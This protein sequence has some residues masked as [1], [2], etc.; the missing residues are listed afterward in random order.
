MKKQLL[1]IAIAACAALAVSS[2]SESD[3]TYNPGTEQIT[4]NPTKFAQ[5]AQS[6][7]IPAELIKDASN[8]VSLTGINLTESGKA[9]VELTKGSEVK[10]V[11]LNYRE[12]DGTIVILNTAGTEVGRLAGAIN[13]ASESKSITLRLSVT[14]GATTYTFSTESPVIVTQLVQSVAG[15]ETQTTSNIAR[16][17]NVQQMKLILEGDVQ[18][19]KQIS[20]GSLKEFADL[21]NERGANLTPEEYETL[22]L[23]IKSLTIDKNGIFA[24]EYDNG[25]SEASTWK[26]KDEA[27]AQKEIILNA[28]KTS[29]FGNKFL[30]ANDTKII[31][32]VNRVG[33]TLTLKTDIKG[34]KNYS[35]SLTLVLKESV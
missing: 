21:A 19:S 25:T 2:C 32:D 7:D 4:L 3:E 30:T 26:W 33:I 10:F 22:S 27:Q 24:I 34:G 13:R 1:T 23:V 12:Q 18:L 29:V 15:S 20:G 14:L 11:T 6:L 31:V 28:R 17:W 5:V 16:T 35:A 8:D 9:I